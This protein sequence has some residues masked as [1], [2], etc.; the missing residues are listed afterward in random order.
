MA[1]NQI[2]WFVKIFGIWPTDKQF[3]I[4]L[5]R[6]SF[7][8]FHFD[9]MGW[10]CNWG[11]VS[12]IIICSRCCYFLKGWKTDGQQ[13]RKLSDDESLSWADCDRD[14]RLTAAAVL[15]CSILEALL[16]TV[17]SLRKRHLC[18]NS[19]DWKFKTLQ[20]LS[21]HYS[22]WLTHAFIQTQLYE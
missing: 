5:Y 7:T 17:N 14:L 13:V 1:I 22:S 11:K 20:L 2:T 6:T 21:S 3:I 8:R 18:S 10:Y 4:I 9:L 12:L 15:L 16:I 19:P